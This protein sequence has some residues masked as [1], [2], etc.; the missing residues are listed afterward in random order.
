MNQRHEDDPGTSDERPATVPEA[1][2]DG[3]LHE[4]RMRAM[5]TDFVVILPQSAGPQ[6]DHA[7]EA[8]QWASR[9]EELLSVYRPGSDISRINRLVGEFCSVSDETCEVLQA[10][11]TLSDQTD[12]AFDITAGPL[13][14]AW[15]FGKRSPR[16]PDPTVLQQATLAVGWR[17]VI[18]DR[19]HG[20]VKL[21]RENMRLNL[22]A[23]GKGFALD[24]IGRCLLDAGVHDFLIH[25]GSST[26]I[27]RGSP[28]PQRCPDSGWRVGLRHPKNPTVRLGGVE[29]RN[30]ALSTS[31]PGKQFFHHRGQRFGHVID[32]RTGRPAG[33]L[34]SLTLL[35]ESATAADALSTALFVMGCE[36]AI[37]FANRFAIPVY[38]LAAQ[39]HSSAV[40]VV[41]AGGARLIQTETT[42]QA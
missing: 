35:T 34:E 5:A 33:D 16:Q 36:A 28:D 14:D 38:C 42:E 18:V 30:S 17:N 41:L 15:G 32:P 26:L 23:I 19:D 13:I 29:V 24:R 7:V 8:L 11:A 39:Q 27:A 20:K 3:I 2:A 40:N 9:L 12:G 37:D 22:G 6:M 4:V 25:G 1:A 10:A 21:A 31:G